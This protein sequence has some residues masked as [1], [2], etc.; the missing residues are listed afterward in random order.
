MPGIGWIRHHPDKDLCGK[1]GKVGSG[2]GRKM[3]GLKIEG[4]E[5]AAGSHRALK[6]RDKQLLD[7]AA[8]SLNLCF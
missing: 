3:G 4:S 1:Q 5:E 8:G 2:K 7:N 6:A